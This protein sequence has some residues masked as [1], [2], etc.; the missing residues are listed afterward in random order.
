LKKTLIQLQVEIGLEVE[1]ERK[2]KT[3]EN[4]RQKKVKDV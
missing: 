1:E 2:L 3:F 4:G